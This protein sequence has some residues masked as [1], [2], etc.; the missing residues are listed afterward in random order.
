[1][2]DAWNEG[3]KTMNYSEAWTMIVTAVYRM[4]MNRHDWERMDTA[5]LTIKELVEAATASNGQPRAK[6]PAQDEGTGRIAE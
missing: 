2:M 4:N 5:L 1:M 6:T 3:R